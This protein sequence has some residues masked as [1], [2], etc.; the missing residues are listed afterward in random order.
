MSRTFIRQDTQIRN[1]D[2]YDDTLAAGVALETGQTEIEGDLNA[3]RSQVKRI[4]GE[5][6][7]YTALSGR[8]LA[9]L[10]TDLLDIETKKLLKRTQ[11]LTD[12]TV[13]AAQNWE[14]LSVAGSEAPTVPAAVGGTT[15]GAVVAQSALNGAGFNVHELIEVAGQ[16]AM[17]PKN[18]CLVRDSTTGQPV[19][20]AGRDVYALLQYESTGA[21]GGTFNDTSAGARVKLSFVRPTAGLDDLEACPSA[22]IAGKTINYAYAYRFAFDNIIED[23]FLT[24]GNWMDQAASVDVTLDNAIDNQSG[25]A[26]QAQNIDVR[27]TDGVSWDFQTSDGGRTLL[28]IAPA[29]GG[30]VVSLDLDTL[31]I[32]NTASVDVLNG[33][34]VDSGGT[35]IS[36]GVTAGEIS[37]AGALS[38]L[39]GGAADLTVR[40]VGGE[41]FLDDVNQTG[42]TWAQT[43]GIKLSDTTSEW[44]NFETA[45]GEVS[46]LNA[47]VQANN[48]A[49]RSKTVAV[50]T[51]TVNADVNVTG[52]A[53]PNLDAQLGDYSGVTFVTDVDIYLNGAL[54]RNGANAAANHD[55]YPGNTPADGDLKFE[56]RVKTGDVI[57]MVIWG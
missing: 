54:L 30:D 50:V 41:L 52:A 3:L 9:A 18:L 1:S 40:A 34:V 8:S 29:G 17:L 43:A 14:I 49:A 27:I 25:P 26:T 56:F 23:A 6:D 21:D 39:S 46:L 33:V 19:Q 7:W 57:T 42:S 53:S 10:S 44:N 2:V 16:N 13:T 15:V 31:D 11:V 12:V 37:S 24:D 20:S 36:L 28:S 38:V 4:L 51:T 35:A 55:V 5:A 48:S 22:D 45:F 47:I 32:N